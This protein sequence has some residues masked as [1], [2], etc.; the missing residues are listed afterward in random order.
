MS[1]SSPMGC[2]EALRLLAQFLDRELA[3]IDHAEVD[4]HLRTCRGC[5]SRAEFERRLREKLTGLRA[6]DVPDRL[7][8]R[9]RALF[10]VAP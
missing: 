9:I 8:D 2:E 7:E 4:R 1:T 10:A 6:F 3:D 5:Y